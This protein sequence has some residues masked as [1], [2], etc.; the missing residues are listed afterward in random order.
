MPATKKPVQELE[1]AHEF[2][3]DASRYDDAPAEPRVLEVS[4]G[5][6]GNVMRLGG[7]ERAGLR[8]QVERCENF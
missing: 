7:V 8:A 6:I 3:T 4:I 5:I 1:G 2:P